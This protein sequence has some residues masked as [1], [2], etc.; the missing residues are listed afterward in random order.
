MID[1]LVAT[2]AGMFNYVGGPGLF[3]ADPNGETSVTPAW[4]S[5]V[6]E[7]CYIGGSVTSVGKEVFEQIMKDS[8][9]IMDHVRAITPNSGAY[10][11]ES[12]L[13]EPN[14]E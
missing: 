14:W 13:L 12:A 5:T 4:R 3:E 1:A 6:A 7:Y 2:N 8:N 9:D 11:N 10:W